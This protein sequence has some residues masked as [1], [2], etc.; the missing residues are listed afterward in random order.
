MMWG[1][2]IMKL[3]SFGFQ[4][5]SCVVPSPCPEWN[6]LSKG[7][8]FFCLLSARALN[9]WYYFIWSCCW[10]GFWC[11]AV[12]LKFTVLSVMWTTKV[13]YR[14]WRV[15]CRQSFIQ[16]ISDCSRSVGKSIF[17]AYCEGLCTTLW[18]VGWMVMMLR[19]PETDGRDF[20]FPCLSNSLCRGQVWD[21]PCWVPALDRPTVIG[22]SVCV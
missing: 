12:F 11:D 18:P 7:S 22:L 1:K 17:R 20:V 8:M 5:E 15:H 13:P 14:L 2:L 16:L 10:L 19:V 21:S 9:S 3:P 4:L 6:I